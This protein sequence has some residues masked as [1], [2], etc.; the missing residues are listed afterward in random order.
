M[1][2]IT[3][4]ND[5]HPSPL[6]TERPDGIA[7][8]IYTIRIRTTEQIALLNTRSQ[9]SATYDIHQVYVLVPLCAVGQEMGMVTEWVIRVDSELTTEAETRG[10]EVA[11]IVEMGVEWI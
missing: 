9:S 10:D 7:S 4:C 5:L 2:Q 11:F 1:M 6:H 3:H 8:C